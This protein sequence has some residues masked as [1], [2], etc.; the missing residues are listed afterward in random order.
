M[1]MWL[2]NKESEKSPTSDEHRKAGWEGRK[3]GGEG[4]QVQ[5]KTEYKE[6]PIPPN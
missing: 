1:A 3:E 6:P 4:E 2:S 5:R